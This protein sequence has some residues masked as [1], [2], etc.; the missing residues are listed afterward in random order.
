MG[1]LTSAQWNTEDLLQG[2]LIVFLN[3]GSK[4]NLEF[5]PE[6]PLKNI[7]EPFRILWHAERNTATFKP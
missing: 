4:M 3:D 1:F 6:L 5:E 2:Y 7:F